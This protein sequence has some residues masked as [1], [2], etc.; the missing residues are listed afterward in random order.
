[1]HMHKSYI[2]RHKHPHD[3]VNLLQIIKYLLKSKKEKEKKKLTFFLSLMEPLPRTIILQPVSASSCLAV[4]PRGPRI[5]PTKLNCKDTPQEEKY[6]IELER[7]CRSCTCY[8]SPAV[9][10]VYKPGQRPVNDRLNHSG[11]VIHMLTEWFICY[12]YNV[13]TY[14]HEYLPTQIWLWKYSLGCNTCNWTYHNLL[15]CLLFDYIVK[16]TWKETTGCPMTSSPM[17]KTQTHYWTNTVSQLET[18][19]KV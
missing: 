18:L 4:S 16:S 1:M 6:A 9:K 8:I 5:L 10:I 15:F 7:S 2:Y 17:L 19:A 11:W 14:M 13:H 12:I 3:T